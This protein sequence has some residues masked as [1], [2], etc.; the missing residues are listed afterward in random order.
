[1]LQLKPEHFTRW[2]DLFKATARKV[3]EPAAA[4]RAIA[5]VEHMSTCFQA[6]LFLPSLDAPANAPVVGHHGMAGA[7][8]R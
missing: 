3:L 5:K 4:D 7:P 6:G 2:V 8:P 1:M